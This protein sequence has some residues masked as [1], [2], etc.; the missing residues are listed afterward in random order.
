[1]DF[2]DQNPLSHIGII[3]TRDGMAEKVTDLG[4][5]LFFV[6]G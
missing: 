4:G 2:F 3:I 5:Y 1:M 6:I